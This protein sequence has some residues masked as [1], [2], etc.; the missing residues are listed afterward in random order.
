MVKM[1]G[2]RDWFKGAVL[3]EQ[4]WASGFGHDVIRKSFRKLLL[5]RFSGLCL[6]DISCVDS[7][8]DNW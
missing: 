2:L 6:C 3:M 4:G 1:E 5:S 7:D 8:A